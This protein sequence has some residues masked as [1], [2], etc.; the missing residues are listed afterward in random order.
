MTVTVS[1]L[2]NHVR[3]PESLAIGSLKVFPEARLAQVA[4]SSSSPLREVRYEA[5]ILGKTTQK[6][7]KWL[8]MHL[9]LAENATEEQGAC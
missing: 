8:H 5:R 7:L 1:R 4:K 9:Q 2:L 3:H 6:W